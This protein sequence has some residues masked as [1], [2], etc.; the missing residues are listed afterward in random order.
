M[1]FARGDMRDHIKSITDLRG[2]VEKR[3][4]G[5]EVKRSTFVRFLGLFD[6]RLSQQELGGLRGFAK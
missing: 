6:F 5:R 3:R 1:R 2:A 4:S